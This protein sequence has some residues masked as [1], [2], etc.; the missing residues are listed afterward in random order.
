MKQIRSRIFRWF[1]YALIL[2]VAS[3]FSAAMH[4]FGHYLASRSMGY[5]ASISFRQGRVETYEPGGRQVAEMPPARKAISNGGGP[6][7]TMLLGAVFT[8]LFLWRRESFALFAVAIANATMRFNMLIDGFNSDEGNISE[9]LLKM[10]G[11]PFGLMV[12]L[13]VWT[14]SVIMACTLI[15][16]QKF[17]SRSY[18]MI[19]VFAVACALC[20]IVFFQIVG[21]LETA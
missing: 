7:M 3:G 14:L 2:F 10:A 19:P 12:P 4:E 13:T 6:A 11:N 5:Q 18:W 17:C 15:S 1:S 21:R 9:I 8:A 20:W 16:R